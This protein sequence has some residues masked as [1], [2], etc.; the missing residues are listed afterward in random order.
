LGTSAVP[1]VITWNGTDDVGVTGY[2]LQRSTNGGAFSNVALGSA[3]AKTKTLNLAPGNNSYQFRVQARDAQGNVSGFVAGPVFKVTA[4][5]ENA[6]SLSYTGSWPRVVLSGAFGGQVTHN[7]TAGSK[8]TH[9]FT[10]TSISWIS[11]KGANRGKA[12][13]YLDGAKVATIDLYA[14]STQTRMTVFF[15]NNLAPGTHTIE[16]RALGTKRTAATG[17]RVDIDAFIVVQ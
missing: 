8:V 14:A 1:V 17:R 3:T 10:G 15:R 5:Q 13:V 6:A 9:S 7:S 11:T 4:V 2:Q 12:D 16:V